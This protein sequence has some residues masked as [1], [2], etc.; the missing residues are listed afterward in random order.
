M[1]F[2]ILIKAP[3]FEWFVLWCGSKNGYQKDIC[4]KEIGLHAHITMTILN[5]I[6][7]TI[8]GNLYDHLTNPSEDLDFD[9]DS[10]I[11]PI[12]KNHEESGYNLDVNLLTILY[13]LR[14]AYPRR[15]GL[16]GEIRLTG[17]DPSTLL[18]KDSEVFGEHASE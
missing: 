3:K 17:K 1:Q 15:S 13:L 18:V 16:I 10:N 14:V 11:E 12:S 4:L 5:L 9:K 2:L 8:A 7:N 6:A